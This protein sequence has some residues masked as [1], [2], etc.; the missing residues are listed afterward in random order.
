MT[1]SSSPG[2]DLGRVLANS[3][4]SYHLY[5]SLYCLLCLFQARLCMR[6]LRFSHEHVNDAVSFLKEVLGLY[7]LRNSDD[8]RILTNYCLWRNKYSPTSQKF[9]PPFLFPQEDRLKVLCL[10]PSLLMQV[11]HTLRLPVSQLLPHVPNE[12]TRA[13][14]FDVWKQLDM[15]PYVENESNAYSVRRFLKNGCW[16]DGAL[17]YGHKE[18]HTNEHVPQSIRDAGRAVQKA[19]SNAF[20]HLVVYLNSHHHTILVLSCSPCPPFQFRR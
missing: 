18:F 4:P 2:L 16:I 19:H 6:D 12:N 9:F 11:Q 8:L 3:F 13:L 7:A 10:Q 20:K 15:Y 1:S 17:S 14:L 5:H